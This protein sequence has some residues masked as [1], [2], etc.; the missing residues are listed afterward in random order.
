MA[1]ILSLKNPMVC[2]LDESVTIR[3]V[4]QKI[5]K[6]VTVELA[7][8]LQTQVTGAFVIWF[9]LC[10]LVW[11]F[12]VVHSCILV[13][14]WANFSKNQNP[15]NSENTRLG[16]LKKLNISGL[17]WLWTHIISHAISICT[18]FLIFRSYMD[19]WDRCKI[20]S[21]PT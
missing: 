7:E 10:S 15:W 11:N 8:E 13:Q 9:I 18:L 14:T 6:L 19:G 2:L 12:K 21:L 1:L 16:T 4:V 3:T 17:Q 20:K 5:S